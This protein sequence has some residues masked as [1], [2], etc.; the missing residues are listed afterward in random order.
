[1]I[2][3]VSSTCLF[4]MGL[5]YGSNVGAEAGKKKESFASHIWYYIFVQKLADFEFLP[6]VSICNIM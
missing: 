1:M 2:Y 5:S 6:N 3:W 4:A